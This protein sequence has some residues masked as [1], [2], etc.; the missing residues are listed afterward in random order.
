MRYE[1][2]RDCSSAETEGGLAFRTLLGG[3]T[4]SVWIILMADLQVE[5][6]TMPDDVP[7]SV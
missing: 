1:R 2:G 4:E 7:V 6:G 3:V 5:M